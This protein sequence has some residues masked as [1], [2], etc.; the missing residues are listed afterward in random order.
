M[1]GKILR[2]TAG[3]CLALAAHSANAATNVV[4]ARYTFDD[5]LIET[6][7]DTFFV[8]EK[9]RGRVALSNQFAYS[10]DRSVHLQDFANDHDFPELQGALPVQKSGKLHFHFAFMIA[11]PSQALNIALAGPQHF[12]L[13][14]DGISFWLLTENGHLAHISANTTQPLFTP[15]PF[16][17]YVTD[18]IYDIPRGRYNLR[19]TDGTKVLTDL[20]EVTNAAD[21]PGSAVSKYSFIGDLWEDVSNVNYFI[22]DVTLISSVSDTPPPF[23]APGRRKLFIDRWQEQQRHL[24]RKPA[25]LPVAAP[26]D[27]GLSLSWLKSNLTADELRAFKQV[28]SGQLPPVSLPASVE[29]WR[30]GIGAWYQG[31]HALDDGQAQQA[32]AAFA[33]ARQQLP[34]GVLVDLAHIQTLAALRQWKELDGELAKASGLWGEDVRYSVVVG[35]IGF[36]RGDL[37][38]FDQWSGVDAQ[39]LPEADFIAWANA[40]FGAPLSTERLGVMLADP[41]QSPCLQRYVIAEQ[42]FFSLLWRNLNDQ[43]LAYAQ[44]LATHLAAVPKARALW[45]ERSGDAAFL[46]GHRKAAAN[47]YLAAVAL[48]SYSPEALGKLSDLAHLSGDATQER[49]YREAVYGSLR[50]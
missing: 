46:D 42:Y 41:R 23:V 5:S 9:A 33:T 39:T 8:V 15:Q 25:C 14:R 2:I 32:E 18:M 38:V 29:A 36:L 10:G 47:A 1:L 49:N 26:E 4:L 43:A 22:D 27:F 48:V 40:Y 35:Q 50:Q 30:S 19:I 11:D 13:R 17:W 31:C 16:V 3:L 44:R 24:Q 37:Q 28:L 34:G 12:G 21:I 6:G 20:K 7:P 45:L